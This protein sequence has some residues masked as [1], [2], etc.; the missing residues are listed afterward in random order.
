MSD[1]VK[2][3]LIISVTIAV[4][5]TVVAVA[6]SFNTYLGIAYEECVLP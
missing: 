3:L 2:E 6:T 4:V 5:I 1:G